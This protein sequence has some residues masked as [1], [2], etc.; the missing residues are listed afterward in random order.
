MKWQFKKRIALTVS[1][2]HHEILKKLGEF[3]NKPV[4]TIVHEFVEACM[5]MAQEMVKAYEDLQ[6]GKSLAE[7]ERKLMAE[8]LRIASEN[9]K[10]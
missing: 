1:P 4:T 3:Q 10:D 8:G 7:V 9:M 2:E 6:L 5:P